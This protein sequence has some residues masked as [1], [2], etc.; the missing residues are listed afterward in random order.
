MEHHNVYLYGWLLFDR[1]V[2]RLCSG[3]GGSKFHISPQY[4][5]RKMCF[6]RNV[7]LNYIVCS[8]LVTVTSSEHTRTHTND[9]PANLNEPPM[10]YIQREV[11]QYTDTHIP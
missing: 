6:Q 8:E 7:W 2:S 5:D 3:E 10:R 1:K 9:R 4:N 11:R